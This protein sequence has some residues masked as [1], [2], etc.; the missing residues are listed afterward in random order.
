[1]ADRAS[2]EGRLHKLSAAGLG[3]KGARTLRARSA[4]GL[5]RSIL[6]EL[7]TIVMPRGLRFEGQGGAILTIEAANRRVLSYGPEPKVDL[8]GSDPTDPNISAA[9]KDR[10]LGFIGSSDTLRVS[11]LPMDREFDPTETGI[12]VATLAEAWDISLTAN[13]EAGTFL[14]TLM[15]LAGEDNL[16]LGWLIQEGEVVEC[17]GDDDIAEGLQDLNHSERSTELLSAS[18]VDKDLWRFAAVT[19]DME[20]AAATVVASHGDTRVLMAVAPGKLSEIADIWR[21]ALVA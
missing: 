6:S 13:V 8:S 1:M 21:Q 2:L 18:A 12:A 3:A 11:Y 14:D 10:L 5:L 4:V 19:D 9:F 15:A 7:D 16:V 17:V 20:G